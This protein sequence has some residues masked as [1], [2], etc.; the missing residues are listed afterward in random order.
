MVIE[1]AFPEEISP[2]RIVKSDSM[3]KVEGKKVFFNPTDLNPKEKK[4]FHI[5]ARAVKEGD[6]RL[7]VFMTSEMLRK[8]VVEEESTHVY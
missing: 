5:R 8:P 3:G 6:S 1:L 4:V 7:K 2:L